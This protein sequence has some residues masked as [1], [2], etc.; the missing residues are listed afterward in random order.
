MWT[1]PRLTCSDLPELILTLGAEEALD[2]DDRCKT[3]EFLGLDVPAE[4]L[5]V[6]AVES[7]EVPPPVPTPRP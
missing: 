3:V 5:P 2:T 6:E 4:A 1:L 7:E